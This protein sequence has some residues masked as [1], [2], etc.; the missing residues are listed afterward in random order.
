MTKAVLALVLAMAAIA[1]A[2]TGVDVI[3]HTPG[4]DGFYGLYG[5]APYYYGYGN[6]YFGYDGLGFGPYNYFGRY[7]LGYSG[8]GLGYRGYLGGL[9]YF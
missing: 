9:G 4:Y 1:C 5:Y 3:R 7:G 8:Y 6:G 2:S